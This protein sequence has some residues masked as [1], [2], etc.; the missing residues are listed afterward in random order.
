MSTTFVPRNKGI[1]EQS[2]NIVGAPLL[3]RVIGGNANISGV[4]CAD[5]TSAKDAREYG[6]KIEEYLELNPSAEYKDFLVAMAQFFKACR[7]F[8]Q[9]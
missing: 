1:N 3:R 4:G 5:Y 8:W 9:Y 7:G 6:K 2:T